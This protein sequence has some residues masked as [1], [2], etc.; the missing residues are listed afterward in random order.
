MRVTP[1]GWTAGQYASCDEV[2]DFI[3]LWSD[4]FYENTESF[5]G[6]VGRS[7]AYLWPAI[8]KRERIEVTERHAIVK[9]LRK[10]DVCNADPIWQFIDVA[11]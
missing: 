3:A 10:H 4:W 6:A 7:L 2:I 11:G 1:E 9:L 5:N 8:V